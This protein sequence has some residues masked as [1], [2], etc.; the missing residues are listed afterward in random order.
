[1]Q[2]ADE[3][4]SSDGNQSRCSFV[5]TGFGPFA[6]VPNNPTSTLISCL[7]NNKAPLFNDN[8]VHIRETHI[9]DTSAD[10]AKSEILGIYSRL[11]SDKL[12]NGGGGNHSD[13]CLTKDAIV[14]IHLGVNYR[15]EKMRLEQCAYNDATFR[16]P[17]NNGYQ[18]Q[19]QCIL[20]NSSTFGYCLQTTLDL[21]EICE[22]MH[23]QGQNEC[24]V[25]QD[26]GRFVCNYTYCLSLDQCQTANDALERSRQQSTNQFVECYSLFLHVTPFA[27]I[28]KDKQI[29]FIYNLLKSIEKNVLTRKTFLKHI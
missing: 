26:P 8:G 1:M 23:Q 16:V 24:C 14:V 12:I 10:A 20:G 6:G 29:S 11:C 18:P 4:K 21:N 15:G 2:H 25:S 27:V 28:S 13:D 9:L 19:E 22:E 5:I 17:D 3:Q 7:R